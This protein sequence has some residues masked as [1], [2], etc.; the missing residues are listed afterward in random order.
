MARRHSQDQSRAAT[1]SYMT[2][3]LWRKKSIT[4]SDDCN[5]HSDI[6]DSQKRTTQKNEGVWC[7]NM[8]YKCIDLHDNILHAA[9]CLKGCVQLCIW[10]QRAKHLK[11]AFKIPINYGIPVVTNQYLCFCSS[12]ILSMCAA[13]HQGHNH[14]IHSIHFAY[15]IIL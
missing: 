4:T 2:C 12:S 14:R 11:N 6:F 9:V 8:N 1:L 5:S 3:T 7:K 13:Q 10:A 15:S